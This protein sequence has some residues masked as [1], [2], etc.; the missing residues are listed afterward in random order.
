[1][2]LQGELMSMQSRLAAIQLLLLLIKQILNLQQMRFE[3]EVVMLWKIVVHHPAVLLPGR[4]QV[5]RM[6]PVKRPF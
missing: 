4:I 2:K 3:F 1:M 6:S 5:Y